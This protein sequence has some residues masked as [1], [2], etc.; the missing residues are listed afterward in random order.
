M[1]RLR[2]VVAVL[3]VHG[4]PLAAQTIAYDGS[5]SV[6]T[7]RYFFTE[8][9]T[10]IALNSGI[11]IRAGRFTFRG[12]LP[13]WWQ[14][15]TLV[16]ATGAGPVP[17][18]GPYGRDVVRDSGEAR[19]QRKGPGDGTGSDGN[20][21][22]GPGGAGRS[23]PSFADAPGGGVLAAS[24]PD[25]PAPSQSLT[26]Y[27]AV[28][29]DPTVQASVRLV[30]VSRVTIGAGLAAKIPVADTAGVGTGEWDIGASTSLTIGLSS[31][32]TLGLDGSYWYLGDL[33]AFDFRNPLTGSA[34]V[35]ALL[36]N[37]WGMLAS[38]SAG[39]PA[40]EGYDAPRWVSAALSRFGARAIFG[41]NCSIGL[42]ET[43]PDVGFG[44]LWTIRLGSIRM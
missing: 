31:R 6:S 30:S 35:G 3:A 41:V 27:E 29:A 4:G 10:S 21:P 26:G 5:L 28:I 39:T 38:L 11:S 15:T 34:S 8:R 44:L 17:G 9:T 40:L 18:G 22:G 23:P 42:S 19:Q 20:G 12:T 33:P 43:V 36:G 37:R 2:L 13:V 1:N 24:D 32:V 14:N 7:G 16:T 25:V